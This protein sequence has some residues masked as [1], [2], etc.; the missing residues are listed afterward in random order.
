MC[1]RGAVADTCV[2]AAGRLKK[3]FN[4]NASYCY[5][6]LFFFLQISI[7]LY[8][9]P[10]IFLGWAPVMLGAHWI[11][12]LMAAFLSVSWWW[13]WQFS[14]MN[15]NEVD[16]GPTGKKW[17]KKCTMNFVWY[18]LIVRYVSEWETELDADAQFG[19][20]QLCPVLPSSVFKCASSNTDWTPA[21]RKWCSLHRGTWDDLSELEEEVC[22]KFRWADPCCVRLSH[23][24]VFGTVE[25]Q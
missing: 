19:R 9:K 3:G 8:G 22:L 2:S 15:E 5:R 11:D 1:W 24:L 25:L 23:S 14:W 21:G 18:C 20:G 6:L 12:G 17:I 13:W 10:E 16:G 4:Q 7:Q